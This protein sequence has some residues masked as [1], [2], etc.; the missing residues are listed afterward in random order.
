[1]TT[2]AGSL[3]R[4]VACSNRLTARWAAADP[5]TVFSGVGIWLLLG[6][7]AS[8]SG[9]V[10]ASDLEAAV[11]LPIDAAGF[12]ASDLFNALTSGPA[13]RAALGI[14][15]RDDV[16]IKE[17]W[18]QVLPQQ[19]LRRLTGE[20]E[21]DQKQ[22]DNWAHGVT[23]GL[24]PSFPIELTPKTVMT[25]ATGLLVRTA[26]LTK[27]TSMPGSFEA[28]PWK[29][30]AAQQLWA[31]TDLN[32]Q[33]AVIQTDSGPLTMLRWAGSDGIDVCLLLGDPAARPEE[34]LPRGIEFVGA[35]RSWP[36]VQAEMLVG[37]C[38][39]VSEATSARDADQLQ[40]QTVAFDLAA[41]HDLLANAELFGLSN[42]L[43]PVP[44]H[45]PAI[46]DIPLKVEKAAQ[47]AVASFTAEGFKAAAVT[48]VG[49]APGSAWP[50]QTYSVKQVSLVIERPFGFVAVDRD[51]SLVIVA[52]WVEQPA[53]AP[54]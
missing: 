9:G 33:I 38:L 15:A 10:V 49:L 37:P 40:V 44:G 18:S 1:V 8:G 42:A 23:D 50:R 12:A 45:F 11:G 6:W 26:W 27:F 2:D 19:C 4:A 30:L 3:E 46:S 16:P 53:A 5:T 48:A 52:G 13:V 39:S 51:T 43:S 28:G 35:T 17:A 21:K 22:L 41:R 54:Q 31:A 32:D 14:W 24:I 20:P 34:V 25:L 36:S 29:G 7:L 47:S